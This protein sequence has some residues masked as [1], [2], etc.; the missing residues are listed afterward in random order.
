M[1]GIFFKGLGFGPSFFTYGIALFLNYSKSYKSYFIFASATLLTLAFANF[2]Y[3]DLTFG[4]GSRDGQAGLALFGY[5]W[6]LGL[7]TVGV[8]LL[9]YFFVWIG[10]FSKIQKQ[11]ESNKTE[12]NTGMIKALNIIMTILVFTGLIL[13][14]SK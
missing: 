4:P 1:V 6:F 11:P 7:V 5:P 8:V 10:K 3:F 12:P 9:C 14:F 13:I 2:A